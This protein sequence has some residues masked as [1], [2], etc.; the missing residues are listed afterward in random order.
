MS[1]FAAAGPAA[2]Q[3]A[4]NTKVKTAFMVFSLAMGGRLRPS[5]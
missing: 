3:R 2:R 1:A 4:A 5:R